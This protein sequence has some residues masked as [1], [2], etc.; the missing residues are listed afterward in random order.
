MSRRYGKF[1]LGALIFLVVAGGIVWW[2]TPRPINVLVITLDTTRADRLGCYGAS[3]ALTPALDELARQGVLFERAYAPVPLT[4]PSH[5]SLF[6]GLYPPEHG[7][8][9]NGQGA[10]PA[11]LPTLA[12]ALQSSRYETG[13]FVASVVLE[14]KY[15]LNRGFNTYHDDMSQ[16][17][18]STQGHHRYRAANHV[19]DAALAWLRPRRQKPFF[20]W[21][22][23]FDPH[24]PY[25]AHEDQFGP[26]FADRPYDGEIAF[27]DRELQRLFRALA[28]AGVLERT[29]IVVAGDHG[30]SLGEHGE[31]T[32]SM[33]LYDATLR[34]P[35]LISLPGKAQPGQRVSSPVSLV[36]VTPTILAVLGQDPIPGASGQSLLPALQAK[37]VP[38]TP[39]YAETDEPFQHAHWSPQRA[40]ITNEWKYIRSPQPELYHLLDDPAEL[41]NRLHDQPEL[42]ER[43]LAELD[44][45][46]QRM[47]KRLAD[48]VALSAQERQMLN[49]LGYA[50]RHQSLPEGKT[51][52]PDVKEML[53]F[54][55]RLN[56]A[57]AMMDAGRYD[58]AEPVLREI[59]AKH[60]EY[61]LAHG[62][63]GRCLV[64]TDRL[65]EGIGHLRRYLEF[66]PGADRVRAMLGAALLMNEDVLPAIEELQIVVRGS[67]D[68][69]ESRYNLGLGLE[70]VK[71]VP[72]A[73]EHYEACLELAPHFL[74]ARQRLEKLLPP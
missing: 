72:E 2:R 36:D 6:T 10:L 49:S 32:H 57:T 42:A 30:E 68:L 22:H 71:R 38:E 52:L 74:P 60:D 7:V 62:D 27:V 39:C 55:N 48:N 34:V 11:G 21:V 33:T 12:T 73:I 16:A 66:D 23:L 63:L 31:F 28:E 18:D 37:T 26:A 14:R 69:L 47:V 29:L 24:Y 65:A 46:E 15:G 45:W 58:L 1:V 64:R 44:A 70:K 4:L 43:L 3:Q 17:D 40:L 19:I 51:T 25:L 5:A 50:A 41:Q 13:A 8:R 53:P 56:D 20:C 9:N 59:L 67:P 54:Y 35:L 61:F